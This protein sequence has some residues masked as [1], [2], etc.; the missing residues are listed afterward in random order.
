MIKKM[1]DV[2]ITQTFVGLADIM[3]LRVV[4]EGVETEHRAE[5]LRQRGT[6]KP[7][8]FLYAQPMSKAI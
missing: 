7:N 2:A 3:Q 4:G 1:N 8:G 5:W 6:I